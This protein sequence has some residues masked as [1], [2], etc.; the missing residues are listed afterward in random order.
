MLFNRGVYESPYMP[1]LTTTTSATEGYVIAGDFSNYV[2]A[3]RG[4]MSVELIP[5]IFQQATAGSAY[6]M[7]TGQRGWF[8]Y[9]RIGGSS[10]NDLG[11]RL[12]VN[13]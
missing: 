6:G 2:V 3:R 4:G 12:L 8:A 5:Q 10:A 1:S 7:P 11:F 13:T 9:S